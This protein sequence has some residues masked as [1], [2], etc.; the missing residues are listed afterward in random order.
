M[1]AGLILVFD[2]ISLYPSAMGDDPLYAKNEIVY[3]FHP[4]MQPNLI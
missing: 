2:A 4:S 3:V 1:N